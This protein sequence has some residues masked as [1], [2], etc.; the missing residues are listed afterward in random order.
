MRHPATLQLT[1]DL[2]EAL[3]AERFEVVRGYPIRTGRWLSQFGHRWPSALTPA[4]PFLVVARKPG[5]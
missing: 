3:I 5:P 1:Y 2:L 4:R